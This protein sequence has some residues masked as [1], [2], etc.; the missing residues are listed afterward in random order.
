M[1]E[2]DQ[3]LETYERSPFYLIFSSDPIGRRLIIKSSSSLKESLVLRQQMLAKLRSTATYLAVAAYKQ[4]KGYLPATLS[5]LVPEY[6]KSVPL[7]PHSGDTKELQYK[8]LNKNEWEIFTVKGI[9]PYSD[10]DKYKHFSIS[11]IAKKTQ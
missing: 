1:S 3:F 11:S 6:I 5:A 7:D 4:D 2:L 10:Q 9:Y 8:V